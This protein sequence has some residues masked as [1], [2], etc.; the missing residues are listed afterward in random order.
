MPPKDA[1]PRSTVTGPFFR[2]LATLGALMLFLAASIEAAPEPTGVYS[3]LKRKLI[4][5]GFPPEEVS[6]LYDKGMTPLF[7]TVSQTMR[8]RES[9]LNY[10]GFLQPGPISETRRFVNRN[11]R[12][13]DEVEAAYGVNPCVIAAIL[14]IE[15]HFGQYTGKTPT[16]AILSTFALMDRKENRDKVWSLLTREDQKRWGREQF[17]ERLLKRAN[18]AYEE[19]RSLLKLTGGNLKRATAYHGSV[20][21]AIGWPQFLPS[22]LI[23]WGVDGDGDGRKDLFQLEDAVFSIANYLRAH[24][25]NDAKT[26]AEMEEVIYTYNHSRPYVNAVLDVADEVGECRRSA[27]PSRQDQG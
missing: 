5:D 10:E 14:L 25:W 17:D 2:T 23:Q 1:T 8:M 3:P 13:L 15:T 9:K 24:G 26:R 7:K 21:G 16:F 4:N 22:S 12:L 27:H 6:A 18:W 11:R 19:L 20:M